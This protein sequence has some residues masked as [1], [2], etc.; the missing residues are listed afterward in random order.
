MV[1][2]TLKQTLLFGGLPIGLFMGVYRFIELTATSRH[3]SEFTF[4]SAILMYCL[5]LISYTVYKIIMQIVI[6][7]FGAQALEAQEQEYY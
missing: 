5:F 3:V 4:F 2:E 6:A 7:H 1:A